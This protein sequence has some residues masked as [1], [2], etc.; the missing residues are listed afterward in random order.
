MRIN[1]RL[2]LVMAAHEA[3]HLEFGTFDL[4]IARLQDL[5]EELTRRYGR[6]VSAEARTL[7]R[8]LRTVSP[9]RTDPR[10]LGAC[11]GC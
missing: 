6:R 3:G 5:T 2:Y 7:G 4:P 8:C 10:S 11:R 9:A 1:V